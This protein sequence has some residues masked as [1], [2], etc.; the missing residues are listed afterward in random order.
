MDLRNLSNRGEL[1][2]S[3]YTTCQVKALVMESGKLDLH[4]ALDPL[5]KEPNF[6]IR[7]KL[8]DLNMRELNPLMRQYAKLDFE[9]GNGNI[10]LEIAATNGQLDGYVKP[11]FKDLK[12]FSLKNDG[13][14]NFLKIAWEALAEAVTQIFRNQPKDQLATKT[15]VQGTI[16]YPETGILPTIGNVLRNAFFQAFTPLYEKS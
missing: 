8:L 3:R 12:I 11:L 15:P 9:R 1:T 10:V 4:I 16:K 13:D 14:E 6:T 5:A 2:E 7:G